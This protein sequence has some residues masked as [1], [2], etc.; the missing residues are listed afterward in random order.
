MRRG[1]E[2]VKKARTLGFS[3]AR[4]ID[5]VSVA[6]AEWVRW[7]CQFGCDGY[8]ACLTCPPYSPSPETTRKVLADYSRALLLQTLDADLNRDP[9]F[10]AG[11]RKLVAALEREMFLDGHY[12]AFGMA[13]G[14]CGV[15]RSCDP[16]KGCRK[17]SLARPSMEAC[18][19]DVYRTA[20]NNGLRLEVVGSGESLCAFVCLI[21]ID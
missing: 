6:V 5:P 21:L 4:I 7:K 1:N 17:P 14:P 13:A 8:G 10:P 18:G 16:A 19:I 15:C 2:Y 20:R 12:K 9:G 3:R 11:Q